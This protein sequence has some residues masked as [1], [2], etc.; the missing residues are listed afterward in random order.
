MR[1]HRLPQGGAQ[2]SRVTDS[3]SATGIVKNAGEIHIHHRYSSSGKTL[4][5]EKNISPTTKLSF[6]F[7]RSGSIPKRWTLST[8]GVCS[9]GE[10]RSSSAGGTPSLLGVVVAAPA[11]PLV[12]GASCV[13]CARASLLASTVRMADQRT[14]GIGHGQRASRQPG[15][16]LQPAARPH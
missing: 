5:I 4:N 15:Q 10:L 8:Y 6:S 14:D 11:I 1:R 13:F 7:R 16:G 2:L 12:T 9:V 3:R